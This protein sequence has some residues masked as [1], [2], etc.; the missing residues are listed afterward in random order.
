M[1][2]KALEIL[3]KFQ[4]KGQENS[5]VQLTITRKHSMIGNTSFKNINVHIVANVEKKLNHQFAAKS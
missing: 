5:T 2:Y 3:R 1:I 4:K